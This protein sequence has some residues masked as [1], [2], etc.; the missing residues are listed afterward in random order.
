MN[1][2]ITIRLTKDKNIHMLVP[3]TLWKLN[4]NE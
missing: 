3:T 4:K 2:G 1:K